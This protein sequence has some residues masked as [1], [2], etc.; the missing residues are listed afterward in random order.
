MVLSKGR[1]QSKEN[2]MGGT[3]VRYVAT[4]PPNPNLLQRDKLIEQ[5]RVVELCF[6]CGTGISQGISA[7]GS[8]FY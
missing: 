8:Y 6:R 7:M 3:G 5:R 2:F 4:T 1:M